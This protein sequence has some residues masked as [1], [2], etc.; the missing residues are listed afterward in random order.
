M[1]LLAACKIKI[2]KKQ[3]IVRRVG[4][5]DPRSYPIYIVSSYIIIINFVILLYTNY[6]KRDF[7]LY[8]LF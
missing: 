2:K 8:F 7:Y 4:P 5:T 1:G 6:R 3:Q